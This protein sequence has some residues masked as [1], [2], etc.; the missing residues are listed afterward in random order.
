MTKSELAAALATRLE[1]TAAQANAFI[2]AFSS[3]VE[4]NLARGD[5][6]SIR[7]FGAFRTRRRKRR[8]SIH[9]VTKEKVTISARRIV[10]FTPSRA[11]KERI[12]RSRPRRHVT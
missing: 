9:P 6:I 1:I 12:R 10:L 5:T 11:L 7:G 2:D 3:T 8:F 4:N